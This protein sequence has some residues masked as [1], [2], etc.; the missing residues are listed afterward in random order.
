MKKCNNDISYER[1]LTF[2]DI[3]PIKI[4]PPTFPNIVSAYAYFKRNEENF[5]SDITDD[6]DDILNNVYSDDIHDIIDSVYTNGFAQSATPDN[7]TPANDGQRATTEEAKADE[8]VSSS[9]SEQGV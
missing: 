9:T 7:K 5:E 8:G 2:K 6:T 1:V 4:Y 3:H